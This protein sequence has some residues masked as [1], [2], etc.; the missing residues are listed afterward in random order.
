MGHI[1]SY[2]LFDCWGVRQRYECVQ[3]VHEATDRL[4]R[5]RD[6]AL[7]SKMTHTKNVT[8][9][10]TPE[11]AK[12][13]LPQYL[14][15]PCFA[16]WDLAYSIFAPMRYISTWTVITVVLISIFFMPSLRGVFVLAVSVM[17]IFTHLL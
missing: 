9:F 7:V 11:S 2:N 8:T 6:D 3:A 16:E 14:L 5:I 1:E 12:W 15:S 17:M 10:Y 13:D 4:N